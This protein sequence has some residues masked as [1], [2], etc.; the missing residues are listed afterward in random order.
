MGMI[1]LERYLSELLTMFSFYESS[2][3]A[4]KEG[5][6][7]KKIE[8][9]QCLTLSKILFPLVIEE[10]KESGDYL[11]I[12][13][14]EVK[15]KVTREIAEG[16][17]V[18]RRQ[19]LESSHSIFEKYLCHVVRVYFHTFPQ[20]LKGIDKQLHFRIVAELK[21][22][23]SIFDYAVETEVEHFSRRSLQEKKDYLAKYLKQTHQE[24][25]WIYE[26]EELWKDIDQKRQAIVH[27]EEIPEIS[28]DYLLRASNHLNKIMILIAIFAQVDQGIKFTWGIMSNYFRSKDKPILR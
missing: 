20:I 3:F 25:V 12:L 18:L 10:A 23:S 26:G 11:K 7:R 1:N 4:L 19:I 5:E 27:K 13:Q 15:K 16:L 22:N 17:A 14:Q 24:E 2:E 28:H 9:Q 21:D 6:V 8:E